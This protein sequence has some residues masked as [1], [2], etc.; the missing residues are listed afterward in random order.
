MKT[1]SSVFR[2][3]HELFAIGVDT[4]W[5]ML[6]FC[7][8]ARW[9][10]SCS[11]TCEEPEVLRVDLEQAQETLSK[12][13]NLLEKLSGEKT[14]WSAQNKEMNKDAQLLP[15]NSALAAAWV[16]HLGKS[17]EDLRAKKHSQPPQAFPFRRHWK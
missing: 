17:A 16:T 4:S 10:G 14:R 11:S 12:A 2:G 5:I 9:L 1:S 15:V 7:A 8:V 13:Q 6:N 3:A